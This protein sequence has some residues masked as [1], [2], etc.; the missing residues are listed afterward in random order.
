[1]G[2][3]SQRSAEL[4]SIFIFLF[5]VTFSINAVYSQTY[6]WDDLVMKLT[7][8]EDCEYDSWKNFYDDL[9]EIHDNPYN[10]NTITKDQLETLP[11]LT[12]QLIENILYY[13]SLPLER[14]VRDCF[15]RH[16]L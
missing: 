5:F 11:F 2:K 16:H 9:C 14:Q 13:L 1:M 10:I 7:S 15:G 6:T 4:R 8:E 3:N 12:P